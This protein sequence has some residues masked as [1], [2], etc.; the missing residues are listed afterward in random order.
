MQLYALMKLADE[1]D[2]G[3]ELYGQLLDL[4]VA[5]GRSRIARKIQN[6]EKIKVT[7]LA[8]SATEW[9]AGELYRLLVEDDRIECCV[10]IVPLTDRDA[11][12]DGF[13]SRMVSE[14]V[15]AFSSPYDGM[16]D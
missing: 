11:N 7:F 14:G 6:G 12:P 4:V 2:D 13:Q 10:V 8:I 5:H 16:Y 1:L 3:R 9:P 15:Q